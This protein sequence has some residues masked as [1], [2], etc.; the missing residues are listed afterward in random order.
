M[1][2]IQNAMSS[3]EKIKYQVY[4]AHLIVEIKEVIEKSRMR[5]GVSVNEVIS[6]IRR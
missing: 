3:P 2:L 4:G 6:G 5:K 1:L